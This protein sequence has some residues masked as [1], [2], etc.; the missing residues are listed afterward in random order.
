MKNQLRL[1]YIAVDRLFKRNHLLNRFSKQRP[2]TR[3]F[4]PWWDQN[5]QEKKSQNPT[6]DAWA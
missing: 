6:H 1:L 2:S 5:G 3:S 4:F